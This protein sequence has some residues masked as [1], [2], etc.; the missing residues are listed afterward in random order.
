MLS[1]R[2]SVHFPPGLAGWA[3]PPLALALVAA[4]SSS[5]PNPGR[6]EQSPG[7][8]PAQMTAADRLPQVAADPREKTLAEIASVLLPEKHLLRHPIDDALSKE[9][10][11]QYIEQLDG[12][13]LFL[14]QEHVDTLSAYSDR[15]DDEVRGRDLVLAR[16]GAALS[17]SRRQVVAK[18][19]AEVLATPF[20]FKASEEYETD[21]KKI[22]FCKT[23]SELRDRWRGFLKL[24]ALERIQQMESILE[25][26]SKHAADKNAKGKGKKD[27]TPPAAETTDEAAQG[28]DAI[29]LAASD[30]PDTFEGREEKARKD[31]AT[32]FETRFTRLSA[33]EPLEPTEQFLNALAS[34]LDPHTQYL[35]PAEK[36]NF[37][38]A[39]SGTVEGIGALL[40]EQDHYVVVQELVPGGAAWQDGK[41]EAG[42]LIVAVAQ[43]GKPPVDVTDMP[44]DKVVQMIRGAKGTVVVLTVK[45]PEGEIQTI[46][47]T[48]DVVR[49]EA[50]YARGAILDLGASGD[51]VGYIGLPGFYGD[52]GGPG[53]PTE[54]NATKDVR[55]LLTRFETRKVGAVILD[56]RGN[57]G[58]ILSHARDISGLFLDK[59]PI[60]QVRDAE[61]RRE[62]LAD[63]DASRSFSGDVVVLVD[64]FSASASE[65]VAGAL[66]DYGRAVIVGTGP[67]HG[68]G[69]VQGVIELDQ[70]VRSKEPLGVFK[71]T[72]QQ[73][74]RVSGASTQWRGVTPDIL[75]PDPVPFVESGERTLPHS[76]P[77]TS[78]EALNY[79]REKHA[80]AVSTLAA[81]SR[82]RVKASSSFSRLETFGKLAVERRKDTSEPLE[83]GAW[84]AER[85]RD[86][87]AL[88]AVSPKVKDAKPLF[89]IEVV[90]DA[91]GTS[92][93]SQDK[94]LRARLDD[95]KNDLVKDV[96]VEESLRVVADMTRKPR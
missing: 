34:A 41:L 10:F 62:V 57:G 11:P 17:A 26:R 23:E 1:P 6:H 91:N 46:A 56:L 50:N 29:A 13:K 85:A 21:P 64:R 53:G 48:R 82:D 22:A 44:L 52:I 2:R 18:L 88:E 4:C 59:G 93:A 95:W 89:E 77:W 61:G 78:V 16:K 79:S 67:T 68:K 74:F 66:Q 65:I 45:K 3:L 96:W 24:Q 9:A 27:K 25:M 20:D 58:G 63:E 92:V 54:R 31:L 87:E 32:R 8:N 38:I 75:L 19:V 80:W 39:I 60:V 94:K 86:K 36:V 70:V 69:T 51:P 40:G 47:I 76:I 71:L 14:L 72:V 30:I 49:I 28:G 90:S 43:Q 84:R 12:A 15:M 35:A 42:D 5:P 7:G 55:A 81:A 73:Y 33:V 83:I 37:D